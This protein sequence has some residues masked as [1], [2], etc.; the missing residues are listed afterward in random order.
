MRPNIVR[1]PYLFNDESKIVARK[2][3]IDTDYSTASFL[4]IA[5]QAR[6]WI[7]TVSLIF[8]S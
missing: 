8:F 5:R 3:N 4:K 6:N 1:Y 2:I 7:V